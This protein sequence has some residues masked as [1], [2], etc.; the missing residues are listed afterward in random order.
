MNCGSLNSE[1]QTM[2]KPKVMDGCG[3]AAS[4]K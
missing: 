2:M 1:Y 4:I 3:M